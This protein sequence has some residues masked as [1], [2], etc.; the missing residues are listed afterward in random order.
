MELGMK[1]ENL[2]FHVNA[3]QR[4]LTMEETLYSQVNRMTWSVDVRQPL[5]LA[6][7]VLVQWAYEQS[8]HGGRDRGSAGIEA[9]Q[10]S[11]LQKT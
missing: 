11:S 4:A 7:P 2:V 5:S 6:T 10:E 9:L 8:T 3:H 1:C